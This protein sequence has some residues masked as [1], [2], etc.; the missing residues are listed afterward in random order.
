[1][2]IL[3]LRLEGVVLELGGARLLDDL[4]F[5]LE[6]GP[7]SVIL[8]PN[9][10]GKTLALRVCNGLLKPDAGHVAWAGPDAAQAARGRALV[11]QRPMLLRRSA[12]ANIDYALRLRRLP[13]PERDQRIETV[14]QETRLLPLASRPARQ[15]SGGEQQR[16]A[17][18]RAWATDPSV[19]F[20]DEPA[21][22]LDPGATRALEEAIRAVRASGTKIVMTTHD[23]GQA[24][25]MAD[26]I[27]FMHRGHLLEQTRAASFFTAPETEE[28]RAFLKGEVL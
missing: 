1:M 7:C 11:F 26:E 2:R 5:V 17:L 4:S 18:A 20:L 9:G 16:L 15:L 3:P 21:A 12:W 8:G 25:R 22:A 24:E 10:A 23:L 14:L 28:A 19:L 27:L 13:K 6:R